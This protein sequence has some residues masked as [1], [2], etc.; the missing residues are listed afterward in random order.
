MVAA[1]VSGVTCDRLAILLH[2]F[3][4]GG[5]ERIAIGLA[6][7]WAEEGRQV[8]L[9]CGNPQGPLRKLVSEK[10][11]LTVPPVPIKRGFGSRFKLGRFAASIC[12]EQAIGGMFVPGNYHFPA[13]QAVA[14]AVGSSGPVLIAKLSNPV[15]RKDR[16][17]LIQ[18][19]SQRR[20]AR[21]LRSADAVIAMSPA[22]ADD[23]RQCLGTTPLFI[24]P[25]PVLASTSNPRIRG[26]ASPLH[27]L[28]AG[29][30]VAQ[31]NLA[32]A[33]RTLEAMHDPQTRLSILGDGPDRPSVE[34]IAR[35]LGVS[36]RVD[37][38]GHVDDISPWLEQAG[39]FLLTSQY[40]GYPAVAIEALAAGVPV[41]STD[42]SPA[43]HEILSDPSLGEV[44][45]ST[46]PAALA[47]A[48][49]RVLDR[50]LA[51]PALIASIVELHRMGN[52]APQYLDLFDRLH[53]E[54]RQS[55]L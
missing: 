22:L 51:S 43:M 40:E 18:I 8:V 50:P 49:R 10:L 6:N 9:I 3:S 24:I 55:Q 7:Q 15:R 53:A 14:E 39:V 32:L 33:V 2:D 41:V 21:R 12:A 42:C 36:D 19:L 27:L 34:Q 45:P 46:D 44:V 52:V 11:Q 38:A 16:A 23:A 4:P 30:F 5:T 54:A 25:E 31:K 17:R 1:M 35:E 26:P 13:M 29:R 48:I 37:F 28:A 20:M 47:G